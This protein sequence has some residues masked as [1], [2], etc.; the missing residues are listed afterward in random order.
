[1]EQDRKGRRVYADMVRK[2]IV[3]GGTGVT[4]NALV[5]Y[6]LQKGI[7]V[8]VLVRPGS[9]RRSFYQKK[10]V[11]YLLWSVTLR[12]MGKLEKN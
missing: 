6:L 1:M 2:A 3:T 4:G 11:I 5:K 12:V 10:M 9:F 8:I 7:E